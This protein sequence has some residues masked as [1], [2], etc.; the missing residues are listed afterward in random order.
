MTPIRRGQVYY[1]DLGGIAPLGTGE[2]SIELAGRRP[3]VVLSIDALNRVS[4]R[5]AFYVLVVPGTT[6][7]EMFKDYPTNVRVTP[8]E[9]DLREETIFVAHQM[10]SVDSRRLGPHPEA[11]MAEK[12]LVRIEDAVRYTLGLGT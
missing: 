2:G 11:V 3:A 7:A 6:G 1:V 12:A 5:R 8:A 4:D 9:S 10:R